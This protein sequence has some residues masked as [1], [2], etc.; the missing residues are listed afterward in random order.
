MNYTPTTQSIQTCTIRFPEIRLH[1][2]DAHKLRGYF[3][4]LFK[5]QSPL[6]H[7]HWENGKVRYRYPLVQYKV[8]N[9][10]PILVG[11]EEGAGLLTKLF[12][13]INEIEIEGKTYPVYSKNIEV[14]LNT[15]GFSDSLIEYRFETLWMALNQTNFQKYH[16][17]NNSDK[18]QKMLNSILVG[19]ILSFFRNMNLELQGTERLM[20]I[21]KLTEKSTNF[22]GKKMLAFSGGFIIN[23]LLPDLI[24]IGKSASR[25]FGAIR[26]V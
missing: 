20:A 15:T 23:C 25:G 5:E 16:P 7:N 24:G 19:D 3:G 6:L 1:T 12:I 14:K 11:I 17:L 4:N 18:K 9:K 26:R 2:R 8:I 21:V 22:K 10:V 13:N